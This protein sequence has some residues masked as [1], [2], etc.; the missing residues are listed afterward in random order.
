[1][2]VIYEVYIYRALYYPCVVD[3]V[4]ETTMMVAWVRNC[5]NVSLFFALSKSFPNS[6]TVI[7]YSK[8]PTTKDSNS[9]N[10]LEYLSLVN[11]C[12]VAENITCVTCECRKII[13]MFTIHDFTY[14]YFI[15]DINSH[16]ISLNDELIFWIRFDGSNNIYRLPR[17]LAVFVYV[18]HYFS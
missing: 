14:T 1:M 16:V 4:T 3:A 13:W 9:G 15:I 7:T 2:N 11:L 8:G 6:L 18:W 12:M 5:C 10:R 17:N